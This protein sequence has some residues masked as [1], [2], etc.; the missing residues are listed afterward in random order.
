MLAEAVDMKEAVKYFLFSFC[1]DA[2][3]NIS[4]KLSD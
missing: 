1:I 2:K 3:N 4:S